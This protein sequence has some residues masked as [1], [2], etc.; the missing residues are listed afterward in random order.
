MGWNS[1]FLFH[2]DAIG[3]ISKDVNLMDRIIASMQKGAVIGSRRDI[4]A[5]GF[6]NA[7]THVYCA[8]SQTHALLRVGGNDVSNVAF[9]EPL[10]ALDQ[11][12]RDLWLLEQWATRLGYRL[13]KKR[14]S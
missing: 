6:V 2:H 5:G 1:L 13:V 7:V 10:H 12:D 9:Y 3:S 14:K 4:P 11:T 8:P